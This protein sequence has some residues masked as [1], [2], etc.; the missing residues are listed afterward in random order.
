MVVTSSVV[1]VGDSVVV[2]GAEVE[3]GADEVDDSS[4]G[5]TPSV[6]ATNMTKRTVDNAP[7]FSTSQQ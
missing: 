1:D 4:G 2:V 3:G 6:Q 5:A 7:L